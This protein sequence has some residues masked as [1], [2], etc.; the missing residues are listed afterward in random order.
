[1]PSRPV[2]RS[3]SWP[4]RPCAWPALATALLCISAL[5]QSATISDP[6]QSPFPL[7]AGATGAS[8]LSGIAHAGGDSYYAVSDNAAGLFSLDIQV[9]SATGE[10]LTAAISD[11]Q[12]LGAGVDLEGLVHPPVGGSVFASDEVGPAIREYQLS[13]GA[14]LSEVAV[15]SVFINARTNF[16]LESLSMRVAPD[17]LDD[18]LWTAN[19]EAL[20]TDGPLATGTTGSLVRLQRFDAAFLPDGQWAYLTDP[21]PGAPFANAERSGVSDLLALPNGELLVLERSF[22]S[23]GF[24]PRIY[25]VD[26]ALATDISAVANLDSAVFTSVAK[27][28]LWERATSLENYEG[29]TLGIELDAGDHSLLLVSDDGGVAAQVLYA[30]RVSYVPEPAAVQQLAIGFLVLVLFRI[31]PPSSRRARQSVDTASDSIT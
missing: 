9:D 20:T 19:E 3:G 22:S 1:M 30:L 2:D 29:L 15:P 12:T 7:A 28:L 23:A 25:Q 6:L 8:E 31:R 27:T 21:F 17:P 13:D 16:S 26:F 10:I 4:N 5:A 18:A 14:V 11:S 24:R